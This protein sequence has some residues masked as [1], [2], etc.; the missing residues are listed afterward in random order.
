MNIDSHSSYYI[1]LTC[2][3]DAAAEFDVERNGIEPLGDKMRLPRSTNTSE[4][5]DL[6][7]FA[8]ETA[9]RRLMN[10]I[11]GSLY[12][13]DNINIGFPA[14]HGSTPGS[15]NLNQQLA[16]SSELNRRL[17]QHYAT[18][19]I[20]PS[21]TE[22]AISNDK[23]RRLNLHSLYARHLI[24]RPFVLYVALQPTQQQSSPVVHHA[25]SSQSP[26]PQS[27]QSSPF[28]MSQIVLE[29]CYS[30][31]HSCEAYILNVVDMLDKRTPYLW[32]MSQSCLTSFIL[33]FLAS[34]SPHLQHMTPDLDTLAGAV[35]QKLENWATPGSLFEA[36][37]SI[38]NLLL[39]SRHR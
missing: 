32:A 3:S 24:H 29:K 10:R 11:I 18:I 30:C 13:P 8:A 31:I 16:L 12:S 15:A 22:D 2:R 9:I 14:N 37:L 21:M 39:V 27:H 7:Y 25:S 4:E 6:I 28:T 17:D 38:M 20:Q 5:E 34:R 26:T 33:L 19:P 35:G 23:R 1:V 36:L